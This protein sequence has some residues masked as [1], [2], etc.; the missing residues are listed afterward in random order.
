MRSDL[1]SHP[2]DLHWTS[3]LHRLCTARTAVERHSGGARLL[4]HHP[5]QQHLLLPCDTHHPVQACPRKQD[6]PASR[7]LW[8][9][10][11]GHAVAHHCC[12][13][14]RSVLRP[15]TPP[16]GG[17]QRN[18]R[19]NGR[20]SSIRWI[21]SGVFERALKLRTQKAVAAWIPEERAL[22]RGGACYKQGSHALK[23][24]QWL[25]Q[26]NEQPS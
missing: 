22:V 20:T 10:V 18:H 11:R 23:T 25:T 4:L 6:V 19:R 13:G 12:C 7:R 17:G 3:P 24:I 2:L 1:R 14:S 9:Q 16:S 5:R 21:A 15:T 8:A 26:V